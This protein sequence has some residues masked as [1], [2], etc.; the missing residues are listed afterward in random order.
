MAKEKQLS[1]RADED[2]YEDLRGLAEDLKVTFSS[3]VILALKFLRR[4]PKQVIESETE[5][6]VE[7]EFLELD[8]TPEWSLDKLRRNGINSKGELLWIAY[9]VHRGWLRSQGTATSIF[10]TKMLKALRTLLTL[11]GLKKNKEVIAYVFSEL[12]E[13]GDDLEGKID[14]AIYILEQKER[15]PS[16]YAETIAKCFLYTIREG[17]FQILDTTIMSNVRDLLEPW[18][19]WVARRAL[20]KEFID[21]DIDIKSLLHFQRHETVTFV[22]QKPKVSAQVFLPR[23]FSTDAIEK[24]VFSCGFN[25]TDG[26]KLK[27]TIACSAQTFY[28]LTQAIALLEGRELAGYGHWKIQRNTREGSCFIRKYGVQLQLVQDELDEFIKLVKELNVHEQVQRAIVEEFTEVYG[29][30]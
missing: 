25:I 7:K 21:R 24:E 11:D 23:S 15:V 30:L 29:A 5:N 12:P 18:S 4:N 10:V 28:E 19:F 13:K 9:L 17:G 3:L 6:P 8:R 16:Y 26:Y 20:Q 22:L 27:A 14:N 2:L 1:I